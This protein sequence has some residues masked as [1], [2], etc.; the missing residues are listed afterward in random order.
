MA[1]AIRSFVVDGHRRSPRGRS[2]ALVAVARSARVRS[3]ISATTTMIARNTP[4]PSTALA[5][6]QPLDGA[7]TPGGGEVTKTKRSAPQ[8]TV[9]G[10]VRGDLAEIKKRDPRLAKSALAASAL[11]LARELDSD[12]SATSKS[13]CARALLETMDRLRVLAPAKE[14]RDKVDELSARRDARRKPA[15]KAKPARKRSS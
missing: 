8:L 5:T 14:E 2:T 4:G 1:I 7:E 15:G 3:G 12:T 11:A 6:A 9:V 10:A 13:M